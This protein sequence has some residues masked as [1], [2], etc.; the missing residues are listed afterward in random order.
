MLG[1]GEKLGYRRNTLASRLAS[2][3]VRSIGVLVFDVRNDL[4][5]GC[6]GGHPDGGG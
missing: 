2:K 1:M 3:G 5:D 4:M 6:A